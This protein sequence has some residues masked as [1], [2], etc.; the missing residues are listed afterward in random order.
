MNMKW[1]EDPGAYA[2]A[3]SLR[4]GAVTI[5]KVQ[6]WGSGKQ[7]AWMAHFY[8]PGYRTSLGQYETRATAEERVTGVARKWL[9]QVGLEGVEVEG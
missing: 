9:A 4:W 5:G 3:R 7:A 1:R 8:L 2:G 6:K